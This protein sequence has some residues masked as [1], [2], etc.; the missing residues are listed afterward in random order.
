MIKKILV[1]TDASTYSRNAMATAVKYA[2]AFGAEI[3]LLHVVSLP[4]YGMYDF[5]PR[6]F[7]DEELAE[8]GRKIFAATTKKVDLEG[9]KV[10][11]TIVTG[12]PAAE[13]A[14]AIE[15]DVDLVIIGS[16]GRRPLAGAL[17]GSVTQRVLADTR[18]PVLVVK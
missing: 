10:T 12:Y 11:E 9:L 3:E 6:H 15:K 17:L 13:I 2:K 7:N 4:P 16:Q 14:K 8:M 18:C 1:P 5:T